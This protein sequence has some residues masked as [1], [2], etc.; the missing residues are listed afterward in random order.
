[1]N[2]RCLRVIKVPLTDVL[3]DIP[4]IFP[5]LTNLHLELLEVPS[6]LKTAG[7]ALIKPESPVTEVIKSATKKITESI[8]GKP[9]KSKGMKDIESVEDTPRESKKKGK[10]ENLKKSKDNKKKLPEKKKKSKKSKLNDIEDDTECEDEED[11]DHLSLEIGM[12][13]DEIDEDEIDEDEIEEDE[14]EPDGELDEEEGT[15]G[16]DAPIEEEEDEDDEYRGL[17]PEQRI[18]KEREEYTWRFRILKKKMGRNPSI[19][20]PEWNEHS[21]LSLMKSSYK[22]IVREIHL[23]DTID[24]YRTY[25]MGSWIAME[26]ACTMLLGI[27]IRGFYKHQVSLM[28]KYDMMLI[29]LGEKSY[30]KWS[31]NL[32]VELKLIGTVLFQTAIFF[33]MKVVAEN[34]G[35]EAVDLFKTVA[36]QNDGKSKKKSRSRSES[37]RVEEV[38]EDIAP[39][40]KMRGP[41]VTKTHIQT[42]SRERSHSPRIA[43]EERRNYG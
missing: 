17:S 28:H 43:S 26:Y 39:V 25:L 36:G 13:E 1:M 7:L 8:P 18:E 22:S 19:V 4:A 40:K 34:Y 9:K 32:P 21:D 30:N 6:K 37:P 20:I 15:P 11:G 23:D 10:G 31:S 2:I 41:R 33:L 24:T 12:S 35:E 29:E 42:N 14:D 3:K 16:E 27:D 5:K 38:N